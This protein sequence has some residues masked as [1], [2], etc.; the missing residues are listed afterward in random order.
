MP[1][2]EGEKDYIHEMTESKDKQISHRL[3]QTFLFTEEKDGPAYG[4][5]QNTIQKQMGSRMMVP[6]LSSFAGQNGGGYP[7]DPSGAAGPNHY[8][9]AVNATQF[10][11]SGNKIY[12]AISTTPD[13][14]GT[15]YTYTFTST[16]FPDY[17]KFSIW[18]DGYYMTSNQSTDKL[19]V[20]ERDKMLLG[21]TA[22]AAVANFTTGTVSGFFVPLAADADGGLPPVGTACPFFWYTENSWGGAKC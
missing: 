6:T 18:A 20:F 17:L 12:I 14:T 21:Q 10:G 22:K 1:D 8:V 11:Q 13:P 5:D 15:Y 2:F 16:Q 19:F 3:P 9:Q 4:N 7:P